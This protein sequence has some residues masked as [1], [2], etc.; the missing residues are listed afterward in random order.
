MDRRPRL[1][2]S[3]MRSNARSEDAGKPHPQPKVKD[4]TPSDIN[5]DSRPRRFRLPAAV[6]AVALAG[7]VAALPAYASGGGKVNGVRAAV[8]HGTLNVNGSDGGQQVA[9]RL[10]VVTRARSR[11]TPAT[12]A[13]P[14]SPSR[15][16]R[17][18]RSR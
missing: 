8:K 18:T 2:K 11:S 3:P 4:M 17:S 1:A 6:A 12:T 13:R 14:T 10:K 5:N 9:L 15:P 7:V 16:A